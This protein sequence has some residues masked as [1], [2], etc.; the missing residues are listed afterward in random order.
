MNPLSTI[1]NRDY[2]VRAEDG[3]WVFTREYLLARGTC[4]KS[5]CYACPYEHERHKPNADQMRPVISMVPSWTETLVNSS[6]N[7]VGRTRFCIHPGEAVKSIAVLGGTKTLSADFDAKMKEIVRKAEASGQKPLIILDR[8]ENPKEFVDFFSKYPVDVLATHVSDLDSLA[9]ELANLSD[10]LSNRAVNSAA[11]PARAS[12]ETSL[13]SADDTTAAKRLSEYALR[14]SALAN[15]KSVGRLIHALMN[16]ETSAEKLEK[17]LNE[18]GTSIL[19]FIWQKPWM[20]VNQDTWIAA[21]LK[22]C[23]PNASLPTSETRYTEISE[24]ELEKEISSGAVLLF[25]SEP[26]PFAKTWDKMRDLPYVRNAR[27]VALVDGE[28]FSWFGIRSIRFL[29]DALNKV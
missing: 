9:R 27:A 7:V 16:S 1:Q 23:F 14:A 15:S 17:M 11:T 21:S 8:E 20:I 4:C 25:S 12:L 26:F 6:V 3:A 22:T 18:P 13:A 29:E 28:C 5:K 24:D 10:V 2:N 19:Y